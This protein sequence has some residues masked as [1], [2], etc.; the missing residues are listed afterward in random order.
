MHASIIDFVGVW[1]CMDAWT[2]GHHS[3]HLVC[4]HCDLVPTAILSTAEHTLS[5]VHE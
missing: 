5:Q 3:M 1:A 4:E 2:C